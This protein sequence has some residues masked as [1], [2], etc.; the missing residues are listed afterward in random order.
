ME[1]RVPDL[2]EVGK[3]D[4]FGGKGFEECASCW[5]AMRVVETV[6]IEIEKMIMQNVSLGKQRRFVSKCNAT[7][8]NQIRKE[9][10]SI[11]CNKVAVRLMIFAMGRK[12]EKESI[13]D[14]D[15]ICLN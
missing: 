5:I 12:K 1:W 15:D 7:W 3:L 13:L 9:F 10:G 2:V 4:C 11:V 8:H 6:K 14:L